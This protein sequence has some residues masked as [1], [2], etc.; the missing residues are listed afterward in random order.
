MNERYDVSAT[1]S[2]TKATPEQRRAMLRSM[3]ED[4]MKLVVRVEPR[5]SQSTTW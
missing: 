5:N 3:L 2:L 1:S 4:R